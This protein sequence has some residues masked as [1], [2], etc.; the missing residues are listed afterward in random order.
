MMKFN[1]G[2]YEINI[3]AKMNYK[4]RYN[5]HDTQSFINLLSIVFAE[6]SDTMKNKGC[7]ALSEDYIEIADEL[8]DALKEQGLYK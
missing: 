1:V 2:D 8:F 5:K 4:N 7:N 6:A 3:S